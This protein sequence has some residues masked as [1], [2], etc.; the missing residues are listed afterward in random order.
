MTWKQTFLYPDPSR[1]KQEWRLALYI[2]LSRDD[3][4]QESLS[5]SNQRKILLEYAENAFQEAVLSGIYIDDGKSGTDHERPEFKRMIQDI[6]AGK[7]NCVICKNLSRAFRNYSDQG[8]FLEY[9]FP[10]HGTRFITLGDPRIDTYT[11]PDA[12]NGMEIPI[13]GLMNDRFAYKTSVEIRRTFDTKRRKGEFIGAFA[14]YGYKK[15][16]KDKNHLV[17]DPKAAQ[18]VRNIF[19]WY[20]YGEEYVQGEETG[21]TKGGMSKEGIARKLNLL[22]VPN[23][24]A[25]KRSCGCKYYNPQIK[26]NDGLWQGSSIETILSNEIYSGTMVQ[27]KQRVIS[28][29]VHDK[30]SI[31]EEDWIRVPDT[32]MPIIEREVFLLAQELRKKGRRR[33]PGKYENHLF[34]G[35]LKCADCGKAMTR[36]PSKGIIYFNCSTYKRK[37]KEKCSIH[38]IR[39]DALEEG[40]LAVLQKETELFGAADEII[41]ELKKVS[42]EKTGMDRLKEGFD[43]YKG[44]LE[45]T[46]EMTEILYLDWKNG[47]LTHEQYRKMKDR[48]DQKARRIKE[49]LADR[50]K[51]MTSRKPEDFTDPCLENFIKNKTLSTLSPGLLAEFIKEILVHENGKISIVFKCKDPFPVIPVSVSGAKSGK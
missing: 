49:E 46:E 33:T 41:S 11:N 30:V 15:D 2:R 34:A 29:K 18:V 19:W 17:I 42:V 13:N 31:P 26:R 48:F 22:G 1:E 38:S 36:K 44:E 45:K 37:S 32:H 8:Y 4:N 50:R 20:V 25:Y 24:T 28:Y 47:D 39:L 7:I 16:P 40:M 5:V 43:F 35:L 14:P 27:G 10:R 6:K 3:G 21:I 12:V 51:N 23:P 9:F